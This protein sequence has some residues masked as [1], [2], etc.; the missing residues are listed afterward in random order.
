MTQIPN[1]KLKQTLC[2]L[3]AAQPH[4][5]PLT[6]QEADDAALNLVGLLEVLLE[7]HQQQEQRH[8]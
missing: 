6:P 4:T 8:A 5:Q 7:V 2:Q 1:D 3:Y